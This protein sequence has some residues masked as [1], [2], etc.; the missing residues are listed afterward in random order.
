MRINLQKDE[1]NAKQE[2]FC[3]RIF[4]AL[5]GSRDSCSYGASVLLFRRNFMPLG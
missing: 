4:S 2:S 3:G 5:F 1:Q